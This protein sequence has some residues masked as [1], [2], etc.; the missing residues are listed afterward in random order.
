[1]TACI[2]KKRKSGHIDKHILRENVMWRL[3]LHR[4]N[5]RNYQKLVKDLER[6]LH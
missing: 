4:Y 6:I 5:P 1:M 2:Y 3:K